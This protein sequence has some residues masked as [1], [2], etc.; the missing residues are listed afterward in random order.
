MRLLGR[1]YVWMHKGEERHTSPNVV[2]TSSR[3]EEEHLIAVGYILNF[4]IVSERRAT[5]EP[6]ITVVLF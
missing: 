3:V 4:F 2:Q 5:M 1:L 6:V